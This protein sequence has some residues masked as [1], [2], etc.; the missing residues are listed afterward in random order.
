MKT[1]IYTA[2]A[3]F[4]VLSWFCGCKSIKYVPIESKSIEYRD[5]VLHDSIFVAEKEIIRQ[6]GDTVFFEKWHTKYVERLRTD[7]IHLTDSIAI[8]Y[9]V[10]VPVNFVTGWQNFQI[11]LGRSLLL[12]IFVYLIV[13]Y[14]KKK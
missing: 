3:T 6:A 1:T 8:P 12:F 7:S 14:F 9:P 10:E 2:I 13:L 5:R 11:W 4:F